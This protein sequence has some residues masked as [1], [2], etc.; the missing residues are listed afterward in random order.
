MSFAWSPDGKYLASGDGK[1]WDALSGKYLAA[2]NRQPE[3]IRSLVWSPNS[4]YLA[5][6]D[7]M[8]ATAEYASRID[9]P[10]PKIDT[11]VRI[12]NVHTA[13]DEFIYA[14]HTAGVNHVAWSQDGTKIASASA[15][16]TVRVWQA[17]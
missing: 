9:P 15:D 5:V 13:Q 2:Y 12:W 17:I 16:M 1:I 7:N 3:Q 11:T 10:V 14:G 6:F 8:Q 4:K